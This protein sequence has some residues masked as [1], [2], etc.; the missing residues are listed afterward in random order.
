M[1]T[2]IRKAAVSTHL[3][4]YLFIYLPFLELNKSHLD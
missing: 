3:F 4:I 2:I 1:E